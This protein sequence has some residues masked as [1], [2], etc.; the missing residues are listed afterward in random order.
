MGSEFPQHAPSF[1]PM[2]PTTARHSHCEGK[3]LPHIPPPAG[4]GSDPVDV[5]SRWDKR[6]DLPVSPPSPFQPLMLRRQLGETGDAWSRFTGFGLPLFPSG[7]LSLH[8]PLGHSFPRFPTSSR[9]EGR[10]IN[11]ELES[12]DDEGG[13]AAK[14]EEGEEEHQKRE[15]SPYY[16]LG[17]SATSC[18]V[19]SCESSVFLSSWFLILVVKACKMAVGEGDLNG[20]WTRRLSSLIERAI[21]L[22]QR[23]IPCLQETVT[24]DLRTAPHHHNQ[25]PDCVAGS[26]PRDERNNPE[27]ILTVVRDPVTRHLKKDVLVS[28]ADER[29][30]TVLG[31][32]ENHHIDENVD[33]SYSGTSGGDKSQRCSG[34]VPSCRGGEV[35]INRDGDRVIALGYQLENSRKISLDAASNDRS[36]RPEKERSLQPSGLPCVRGSAL[37]ENY[38]KNEASLED[39]PLSRNNFSLD[40]VQCSDNVKDTIRTGPPMYY[41]AIATSSKSYKTETETSCTKFNLITSGKSCTSI[42]SSSA[43]NCLSNIQHSAENSR[44]NENVTAVDDKNSEVT[45]IHTNGYSSEITMGVSSKSIVETTEEDSDEDTI[46][47]SKASSKTDLSLDQCQ[48]LGQLGDLL[49]KAF[50]DDLRRAD[51]LESTLKRR[52]TEKFFV[53]SGSQG[54]GSDCPLQVR[55]TWTRFSLL[56]VPPQGS[57]TF[58]A[59]Q[60]PGQLIMGGRRE[61]QFYSHSYSDGVSETESEEDDDDHA[62]PTTTSSSASSSLASSSIRGSDFISSFSSSYSAGGGVCVS[63]SFSSCGVGFQSSIMR[64]GLGSPRKSGSFDHAARSRPTQLSRDVVSLDSSRSRLTRDSRGALTRDTPSTSSRDLYTVSIRDLPAA[65]TRDRQAV[66]TTYQPASST[67][68]HPASST[69]DQSTTSTRDRF[70]SRDSHRHSFVGR[71]SNSRDSSEEPPL[72]AS[73]TTCPEFTPSL[74]LSDIQQQQLEHQLQKQQPQHQPERLFDLQKTPRRSE[75]K[76]DKEETSSSGSGKISEE[77]VGKDKDSSEVRRNGTEKTLSPGDPEDNQVNGVQSRSKAYRIALELLHTEESYVRIL[78]LIDQEFQFRVDQENRA[79]LMFPAEHL[80]IMFS[81]VK[82][83]YKLHHDFLLPQLRERLSMWEDCPCIGD[84]MTTLAPFL[85]MYTEYVRNFD[86]AIELINSCQAKCAKFAAIMADIH[87]LESCGGLT[88]QHHMLCPVQRIP[89]YELLLRDYLRKLPA[90]HPDRSD[91]AKALHLVATAASHANDAIRKIDEFETLLSLQERISG[92]VDLVSPTRTLIKQG[93]VGKISARSG[94]HQERYLYL[95]SDLLM[96]CSP[97][98]GG[99][100]IHGPPHRLRARYSV[101]NLQVVEGDNLETANTFYIRDTDKTVE[102]YTQTLEE[103]ESWLAALFLAIEDTYQRRSSLRRGEE[104]GGGRESRIGGVLGVEAPVLLPVEGVNNCMSCS[105]SFS[106]V[107]RKHHCRACGG[108]M[109]GKCCSH[110]ASLPCEGGRTVKV[111]RD[112]HPQLQGLC[113]P[114]GEGA[115]DSGSS[116]G[117]SRLS[118]MEGPDL[119]YRTRGVLEVSAQGAVLKGPLLLRTTPRKGWQERFFALHC[120]FVLYS[121]SSS[122]DTTAVTATPLPGYT[123]TQLAGARGDGV[124]DKERDRAFKLHYSKKQYFFL[125]PSKEDCYKWVTALQRAARAEAPEPT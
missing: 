65:S 57:P 123:I 17:R 90:N 19:S 118:S 111:C 47:A 107:R 73:S 102:L 99:R 60:K 54:I 104:S 41:E 43:K 9:G 56:S 94:D 84:I 6:G 20:T 28:H 26:R 27:Q 8:Q 32:T 117:S 98:L 3:L 7:R 33:I 13:G 38:S 114:A 124:S 108:V 120:D 67:R 109:C 115:R 10:V 122:E 58:P 89:R 93:K 35:E 2:P 53:E 24:G 39:T 66:S 62:A 30:R 113:P 70:T 11:I 36:E 14:R 25:N 52:A 69:T 16:V 81:N 61:T 121:F 49:R 112:C 103:K 4:F 21:A 64:P 91:T 92:C 86:R 1:P 12:S 119:V 40:F 116:G 75:S 77:S 95:L 63:S 5:R 80:P 51:G 72:L 42:F 23:C 59:P 55:R 82:S 85:K 101:N 29:N 106:M 83:I 79:R 125:A 68:D 50:A 96:L 37:S 71:G 45:V 18:T 15:E 46:V 44:T 31:V 100:V 34:G 76:E 22:V 48:S 88:L 74:R 97:R 105:A 78:H 87:R 110:K